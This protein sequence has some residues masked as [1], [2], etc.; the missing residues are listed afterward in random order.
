[1]DR[2][3]LGTI[4]KKWNLLIGMGLHAVISLLLLWL[5]LL[6]AVRSFP[7]NLEKEAV[8]KKFLLAHLHGLSRALKEQDAA[9]R[10]QDFFPEGACFSYSLYGL[11][12]ANAVPFLAEEERPEALEEIRF[13][14]DGQQSPLSLSPFSDTTVRYG[15]FWLGQRNL[16]LGLYLR[17]MPEAERPAE[18]V[19]EFHR[20]SSEMTKAFL[21]S[22]TYHLDSYPGMCWPIDNVT[23]LRSL[24]LHDEMYG[25]AHR[26]AYEAWKQWT[27]GHADPLTGMPA[28][29]MNRLSGQHIE[30]AR[31]CANSWMMP[32]LMEMDPEFAT[33]MYAK[34]RAHFAIRNFGFEM[35]REWPH[36]ER[37]HGADVD[38]GPIIMGSGL[39]ATGV[40][41]AASRATGDFRMEADIR[42][43]S[44]IF[45]FADRETTDGRE[46]IQYLFGQLTVGDAFLA[47]GY[48]IPRAQSPSAAPLPS[49]AGLL[50]ARWPWFA[51]LALAGMLVALQAL[52]FERRSLLRYKKLMSQP[53][54][55]LTP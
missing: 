49:R 45:G 17:A 30:T 3:S 6:L 38:S 29:H 8:P 28:G 7:S 19:E 15:V 48:S 34:Y 47:W 21:D 11:A 23:A 27:I 54:A 2:G 1:M 9:R 10:M 35:F 53:A 25:T 26:E 5:V 16:L 46:E 51:L 43:L 50:L 18:L 55:P 12:W 13:A 36:G 42:D 22:P 39:T 31:G 40:G 20:N 41:L 14:L 24:V 44:R 33:A 37:G 4:V 52:Y 32:L